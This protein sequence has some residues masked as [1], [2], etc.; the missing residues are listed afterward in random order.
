MKQKRVEYQNQDKYIF[1][2]QLMTALQPANADVFLVFASLHPKSK[3]VKFQLIPK[4]ASSRVRDESLELSFYPLFRL[5]TNNTK[6]GLRHTIRLTARVR[7]YYFSGG[8]KRR[9]YCTSAFRQ[10]KCISGF[11]NIS[12]ISFGMGSDTIVNQPSPN[13]LQPRLSEINNHCEVFN[14]KT[15]S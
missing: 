6:G 13:C 3:L 15:L 1:F 4:Y 8:E 10:T 12:S 11:R 14:V 5:V 7:R 2:F 9:P